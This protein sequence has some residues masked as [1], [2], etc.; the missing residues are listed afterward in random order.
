MRCRRSNLASDFG[1]SMR[2][3]PKRAGANLFECCDWHKADIPMRSADVCFGGKADM[4]RR[5]SNTIDGWQ[6]RLE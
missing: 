5:L 4:K 6:I 2:D 1:V 3:F